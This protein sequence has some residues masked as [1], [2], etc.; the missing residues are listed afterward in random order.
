V[1]AVKGWHEPR[2][3]SGRQ[4]GSI[5]LDL[6]PHRIPPLNTMSRPVYS[7]W[8]GMARITAHT[9]VRQRSQAITVLLAAML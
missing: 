6:G 9:P 5:A 7:R 8:V 4:P 2:S 3:F 1:D